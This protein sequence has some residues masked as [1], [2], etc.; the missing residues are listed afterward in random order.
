MNPN[1]TLRERSQS[2][3][4]RRARRFLDARY[5]MVLASLLVA[6]GLAKVENGWELQE[7]PGQ[8]AT[9]IPSRTNLNIECV[10][11]ASERADDS[12]V[13]QLQL[14]PTA[15]NVSIRAFGPPVWSYGRRAEIRID[16]RVFPVDVLFADDYVVVANETRGRFPMLSESLLDAMATGQTMDLRLSV[17]M[18]TIS[19]DRGVD[20]YA[21][22]DLRAGQG[23]RAVARLRSQ[24]RAP[25][26]VAE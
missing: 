14:Y 3:I 12:E 17:D 10:V 15:G 19:R 6:P 26:I 1:T 5:I 13:L 11:L 18:E 25:D 22:V 20:G 23:S 4:R 16:E 24:A 21:T 8:P 7:T 2:T 9:A